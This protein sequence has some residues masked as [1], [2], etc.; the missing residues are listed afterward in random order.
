MESK[1]QPVVAGL[2]RRVPSGRPNTVVE[3]LGQLPEPV[4]A[5]SLGAPIK[6][7]PDSPAIGVEA[8]RYHAEPS[9]GTVPVVQGV[10]ARSPVVKVDCVLA[11]RG[12]D[13]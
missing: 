10:P 13:P 9:A 6:L 3:L 8:Q 1:A 7:L 4:L 12:R 11:G 2:L 5:V